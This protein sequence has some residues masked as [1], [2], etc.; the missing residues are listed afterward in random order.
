MVTEKNYSENLSQTLNL[1]ADKLGVKADQLFE[2]VMKQGKVEF[3]MNFVYLLAFMVM[4]FIG[5]Y[6]ASFALPRLIDPK[7]ISDGMQIFLALVT[8]G[9]FVFLLVPLIWFLPTVHEMVTLKLNPKYWAL[10]D[11]LSSV[12]S[13]D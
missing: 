6:G 12:K 3:Y 9:S 2:T 11:I 5:I 13:N 4:F 10:T 7:P 8:V 1:I